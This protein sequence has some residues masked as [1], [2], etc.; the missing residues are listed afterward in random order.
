M[1]KLAS[2]HEDHENDADLG[3]HWDFV[4]ESYYIF[5]DMCGV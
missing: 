5:W 3:T 1:N 4:E 2:D